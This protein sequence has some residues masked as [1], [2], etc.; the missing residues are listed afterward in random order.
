MTYPKCYLNPAPP[1]SKSSLP[2]AKSELSRCLCLLRG[3]LTP[4]PDTAE[5]PTQEM[6]SAYHVLPPMQQTPNHRFRL[7]IGVHSSRKPGICRFGILDSR[8]TQIYPSIALHILRLS[9]FFYLPCQTVGSWDAETTL[10]VFDLQSLT[11]AQLTGS[12][13]K[14]FVG[15]LADEANDV[16]GTGVCNRALP[17]V[18]LHGRRGP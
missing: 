18:D 11:S 17:S 12:R 9:Q 4:P 5:G 13:K 15:W 6:S 16:S 14:I 8:G 1:L 3:P 2:Q 10:F 7:P